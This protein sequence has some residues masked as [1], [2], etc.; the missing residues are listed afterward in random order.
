[1]DTCLCMGASITQNI[2]MVKARG[3]EFARRAVAVIGDST[4]FH[5]GIT[6]LIDCVFSR[7]PVTVVVLDNDITAMTGHQ[8]H[9]GTGRD[10]RHQPAPKVDIEALVRSLGVGFVVTVWPYDL[11]RVQSALK[12][13]MEY[14]GVSVVISRAR[15]ILLEKDKPGGPLH[16]VLDRCD[17]CGACLRIGCPGV[18]KGEDDIITIDE[19]ACVGALC[20]V[21]AQVCKRDAI[22][23]LEG[24]VPYARE[25]A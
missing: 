2:G 6:G 8:E 22:Q 3:D 15:C 19:N 11:D 21:C 13:A 17:Q 14:P 20:G 5:S 10:I 12:E 9:P 7:A 25:E 23:T 16:I 4:F 18:V 24:A 1:M